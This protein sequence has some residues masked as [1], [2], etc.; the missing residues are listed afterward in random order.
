[1]IG[2]LVLALGWF[3]AGSATPVSA[4]ED[5]KA[6]WLFVMTGKVESAS[7]TRLALK[8]DPTVIAFSDRRNRLVRAMSFNAFIEKVW[9]AGTDSFARAPLNATIVTNGKKSRD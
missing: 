3:A 1:M 5:N 9:D 8:P 2:F 6:S 4:A 7:E